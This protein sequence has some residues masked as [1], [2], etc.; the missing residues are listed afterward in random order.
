RS[1]SS[2]AA[3][4]PFL[5]PINS[6]RNTELVTVEAITPSYFGTVGIGTGVGRLLASTDDANRATVAVLSDEFWRSRYA[7]DPGVLGRT[8]RIAGRPFEIVGV[9]PPR[10]LGISSR[11]FSTM[12]WIPL[13]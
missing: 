4:L 6:T 12:V 13:S 9:A 10:F 2:I 7:A 8:V 11:F 3:S 5:A 1:F